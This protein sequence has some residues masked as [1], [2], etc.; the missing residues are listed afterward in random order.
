MSMLSTPDGNLSTRRVLGTVYL[1]VAL[2]IAIAGFIIDRYMSFDV[3]LS[4]VV[5]GG[6]ITGITGLDQFGK[7]IK[8]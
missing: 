2:A 5:A 3:W 8:K 4:I 1:I 6:T 7:Y